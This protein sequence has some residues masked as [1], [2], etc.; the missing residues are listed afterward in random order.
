MNPYRQNLC[1]IFLVSLCSSMFAMTLLSAQGADLGSKTEHSV[2]I[3]L[4]KYTY[5]E[6]NVMTLK[7]QNIGFEYAGTYA[8]GSQWPSAGKS[9]F[10]G[11]DIRY[12][13]GAADYESP[14]SGSVSDTPNRYVEGRLILGKDF[15]MGTYVLAPYAGL[16]LRLLH[17]DL[18]RDPRGYR[19]DSSYTTVPLGVVHRIKFSDQSVLSTTVEYA[20]L[21]SGVQK[22]QLAD[23]KLNLENVSLDQNKGHGFRLAMMLRFANFSF[24]PTVSYWSLAKSEVYKGWFEPANTTREIGLKAQYHF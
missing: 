16:G 11:G 15:D 4:S 2:G 10:I 9:W 5:A 12:A 18:R 22:A 19:R 23:T 14:I 7:A 1:H 13:T 8:F 3:S 24:G 6:P 17:N 21:L 20:H